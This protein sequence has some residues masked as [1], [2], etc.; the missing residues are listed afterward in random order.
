MNS[1]LLGFAVAII[2]AIGAH[3]ALGTI[4]TSTAD[5]YAAPVSVRL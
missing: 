1:M 3:F 5:R 4:Q 2:L